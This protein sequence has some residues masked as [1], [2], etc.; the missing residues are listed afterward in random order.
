M[1]HWT[2]LIGTLMPADRRL[3]PGIIERKLFVASHH[4]SRSELLA[5]RSGITQPAT[6]KNRF[7]SLFNGLDSS[8][9]VKVVTRR[10]LLST[11]TLPAASIA[12]AVK[13]YVLPG[14]NPETVNG[15]SPGTPEAI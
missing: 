8:A 5:S 2:T 12:R 1:I 4:T 3:P 9:F 11:L 6:R 14:L 15:T 10:V 13:W 7:L